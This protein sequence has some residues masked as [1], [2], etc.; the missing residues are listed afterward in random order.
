[1]FLF[2][3]AYRVKNGAYERFL[4]SRDCF[5]RDRAFFYIY[6]FYAEE[7]GDKEIHGQRE[8]VR[9]PGNKE[10]TLDAASLPCRTVQRYG[11]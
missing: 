6:I 3:A 1:M 7:A 10:E 11:Y 9:I 4:T 2:C 5:I 8:N